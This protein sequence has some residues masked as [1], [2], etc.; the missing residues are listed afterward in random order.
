[1][2]HARRTRLFLAFLLPAI[3]LCLFISIRSESLIRLLR[4][5]NTDFRF[6]TDVV[7]KIPFQTVVNAPGEMQST[8]NTV[9]ECQIEKLSVIVQGRSI[10]SGAS[11]RILKLIP[12]GSKVKKDDVLCVLDSSE[13]EELARLQRLN[14]ERSRADHREAEMNLEV[15]RIALEEYRQGTAKQRIQGL[16]GQIAL[17]Q[18]DSS[19]LTGRLEW[20]RKMLDKGYLSKTNVRLDEIS[21]LRSDMQLTQAQIALSTFEKFTQ[22]KAE[23]SLRVR[24]RSLETTLRYEDARLERHIERLKNYEKQI[25]KCTVRAP[26]DGVAVYAN[27]NDGDTRVEEGSEV[28]QG[29]DLF[30]LPDLDHMQV[31]ARL[32]ESVVKKVR[33]GMKARVLVE[34]LSGQEFE[35]H[36][37]RIAQLPIPPTSWRASQDVKNYY[38]L[39]IID[40]KSPDFRPGLNS[41]VQILTNDASETLVISPEDVVVEGDFS[42]CYVL[43]PGDQFEKRQVLT[44]TGDADTLEITAGLAEGET[45]VRNPR[46]IE[47]LDEMI[48]DVVKLP[49]GSDTRD[50]TVTPAITAAENS[51]S[52][53][54][55]EITST[56]AESHSN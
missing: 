49:S 50:D 6:E 8:N 43:K 53:A 44:T 23:H 11:T 48:I 38:C 56:S 45:V 40:S 31:M 37:E 19:R 34:A 5:A 13:F 27:E 47:N 18:T 15:A 20:S 9:V 41:E 28:R 36:V 33:P 26:N 16:K 54:E 7:R 17:A 2:I 3:C 39:V 14:V 21:L 1:M 24:I 42:Y 55:T 25:A 51:I 12:D 4:P 30:Y 52:Q 35:G 46:K 10:S 32:S 29:Q 22:P